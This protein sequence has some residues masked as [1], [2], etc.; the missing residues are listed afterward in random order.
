[1]SDAADNPSS[2]SSAVRVCQREGT[3]GQEGIEGGGGKQH[4]WTVNRRS[5]ELKY[6]A[7]FSS[8]K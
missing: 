2:S 5:G 7:L 1:M 4:T 8:E 3:G 6:K